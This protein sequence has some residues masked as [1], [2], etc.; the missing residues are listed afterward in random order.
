MIPPKYFLWTGLVGLVALVIGLVTGVS[1][2]W[3]PAAAVAA[4]A[5]SIGLGAVPAVASYRYTAWILAAVPLLPRRP[6][7]SPR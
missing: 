6:L 1:A 7:R 3:M 5:L 2:I 4:V